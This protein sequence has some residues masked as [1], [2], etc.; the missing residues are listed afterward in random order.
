[1]TKDITTI[2]DKHRIRDLSYEKKDN[3]L[4][5]TFLFFSYLCIYYTNGGYKLIMIKR[6]AVVQIPL[7]GNNVYNPLSQTIQQIYS[8]NYICVIIKNIIFGCE[9]EA[10]LN[11]SRFFHDNS[12]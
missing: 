10:I 1:M 11:C 2:I 9:H 8:I 12:Y 7:E 3:L 6:R 5:W 4:N